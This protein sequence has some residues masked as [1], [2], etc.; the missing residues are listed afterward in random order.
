[1]RDDA[2]DKP[3]ELEAGWCKDGKFTRVDPAVLRKVEE[4]TRRVLEEEEDMEED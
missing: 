4:E 3:M 1:M 2:K